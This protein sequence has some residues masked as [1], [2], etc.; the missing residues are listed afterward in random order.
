M[1]SEVLLW[2]IAIQSIYIV[3]KFMPSPLDDISILNILL[4]VIPISYDIKFFYALLMLCLIS[5]FVPKFRVIN[6]LLVIYLLLTI[7]GKR[8]QLLTILAILL[9]IISRNETEPTVDVKNLKHDIPEIQPNIASQDA[10]YNELLQ[11][12]YPDFVKTLGENMN[13]PKF[14]AWLRYLST[15]RQLTFEEIDIPVRNLRPTQNEIDVENS[16]KYPLSV[17]PNDLEVFL[18]SSKPIAVANKSIVT[19]LGKYVI[20]GHHR[21]SQL[22]LINP[23]AKIKCLNIINIEDDPIMALKVVQ[24]GI[25]AHIGAYKKSLPSVT[26]KGY[27][28]FTASKEELVTWIRN[29]IDTTTFKLRIIDIF[30]IK[31]NLNTIESIVNYLYGN[32][33]LMRQNNNFVQGA[34]SR[35]LMPQTDDG[36]AWKTLAVPP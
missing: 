20:D 29:T 14:I 8:Y 16:L 22:Y 31:L 9:Y 2:W 24:L 30:R 28:I 32:I 36:D 23:N 11:K 10:A 26:T 5:R 21:W 34:P 33:E 19:L 18:D 15:F 12:N 3:K 7:E 1:M 4:P 35:G 13:D 17:N 25:T 27:N 6:I